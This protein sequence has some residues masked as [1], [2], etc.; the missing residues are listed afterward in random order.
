MGILIGGFWWFLEHFFFIPRPPHYT[1]P[2]I[3]HSLLP[4]CTKNY[5]LTHQNPHSSHSLIKTL[6]FTHPLI[7][8]PILPTHHQEIPEGNAEAVTTAG[9]KIDNRLK[10]RF[11][12]IIP[13]E[14]GRR[15][16]MF[17]GCEWVGMGNEFRCEHKWVRVG[18]S[19]W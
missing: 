6:I 19:G 5:S 13:C 18:L 12:N 2:I 4:H 8:T 14:W 3:L 7:K 11:I 15:G 16:K 1:T 10:N 17:W 9:L